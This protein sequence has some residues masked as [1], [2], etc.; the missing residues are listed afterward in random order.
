MALQGQPYK[1][2]N[3]E[4]IMDGHIKEVAK[5]GGIALIGR[6]AGVILTY[7]FSLLVARLCGAGT[8]GLFSFVLS[9][10]LIFG[11]IS[12]LGLHIAAIKFGSVA[13]GEG[14]YGYFKGYLRMMARL[15]FLSSLLISI[16][17]LSFSEAISRFFSKP[18][19]APYLII[20]GLFF[21][22]YILFRTFSET[23]KALKRIDIVVLFQ[24][25]G[26]YVLATAFLLV[27][28]FAGLRFLSP[29][30]A[31]FSA[32]TFLLIGVIFVYHKL[33]PGDRE[34]KVSFS[35]V[36][37]VSI[38]LMFSG[39][40]SVMLVHVDR[41][42]VG[43]YK[44][45]VELGFYSAAVRSATF[46]S[47]GLVAINYIF[48][49]IISQL[50]SHWKTREMEKIG[51][52]SSRWATLF[53]LTIFFFFLSFGKEFL[54]LFGKGFETGYAALLII[55]FAHI[56]NSAVGSVGFALSMTEYQVHY[57]A[58]TFLSLIINIVA[59]MILI[60]WIG[61]EGAAIATAISIII[62]K[63]LSL[64]LVKKKLGIWLFTE[65]APALLSFLIIYSPVLLFIRNHLYFIFSLIALGLVIPVFLVL[66][67]DPQDRE[68]LKKALSRINIS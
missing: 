66:F 67:T 30:L 36:W 43:Y 9:L 16:F 35:S 19:L 31:Y 3:K 4:K 28:F 33:L 29:V 32:I 64:L 34:E 6:A 22:L 25:I 48:P 38:P 51:R 55:S 24:N 23:Y 12:S 14:N 18:G 21:P 60:P 45:S 54:S 63:L 62:I 2:K 1:D 68:L 56:I 58:L 37:K 13:V 27:Y 59:N 42:M 8:Y 49:P 46:A 5:G 15:V 61:I 65:K 17:F 53:S 44:T 52:R 7:I 20:F 10:L 11:S 57:L 41:I 26:L 50:F 47:F 40:L 39:I